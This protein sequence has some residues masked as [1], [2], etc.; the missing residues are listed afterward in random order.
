[1]KKI[2]KCTTSLVIGLYIGFVSTLTITGYVITKEFIS[3]NV[4]R[5]GTLYINDKFYTVKEKK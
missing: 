4:F 1:M 2:V 5:E 3:K